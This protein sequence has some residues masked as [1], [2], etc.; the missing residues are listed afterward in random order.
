[1]CP[2]IG[3]TMGN[4]L[5]KDAASIGRQLAEL[6]ENFTKFVIQYEEDMRGNK[7]FNGEKGIVNEIRAI[8]D[9][10]TEYPSLIYLLKHKTLR[11]ILTIFG[12]GLLIYSIG[13]VLLITLGPTALIQ[14]FLKLLGIP[15][16]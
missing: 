8:K 14:A 10:H 5:Q 16:L 2:Y 1:M 7:K 15:L 9:Y 3:D 4:S 13:V 12:V 11:T 6:S